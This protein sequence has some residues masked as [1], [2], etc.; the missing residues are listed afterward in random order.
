MRKEHSPPRSQVNLLEG[1]QSPAHSAAPR[2]HHPE[3]DLAT[4]DPGQAWLRCF[5]P[6][7]PIRPL[8]FLAWLLPQAHHRHLPHSQ[9]RPLEESACSHSL[10]WPW[11]VFPAVG[12]TYWET[13]RCAG[14]PPANHCLVA[15]VK[16]FHRELLGNSP[17][18]VSAGQHRVSLE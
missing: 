15:I 5:S 6:A 9:S 1:C 2:V 17:V 4:P 18:Y 11:E 8:C 10:N 12:A 3:G 13:G 7:S 16:L 14:L